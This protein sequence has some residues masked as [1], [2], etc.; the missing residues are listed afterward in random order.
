MFNYDSCELFTASV[1]L[2]TTEMF[3]TC[4][5]LYY[6]IAIGHILQSYTALHTQKLLF[7]SNFLLVIALFF[8]CYWTNKMMMIMINC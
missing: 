8:Y 4:Y 2:A 5:H 7:L 6:C 3:V 1:V